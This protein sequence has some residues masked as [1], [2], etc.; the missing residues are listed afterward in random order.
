MS[1][2]QGLGLIAI[3]K[4]TQSAIG[5]ISVIQWHWSAITSTAN[6]FS[7]TIKEQIDGSLES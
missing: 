5:S 1:H 6:L 2:S 3:S 7:S 4:S